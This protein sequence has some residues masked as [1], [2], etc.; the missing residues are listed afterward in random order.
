MTFQASIVARWLKSLPAKVASHY[1][2]TVR[3]WQLHLW[4]RPLLKCMRKAAWSNPSTCTPL[5]PLGDQV[6]FCILGSS[7]FSPRHCSR[8]RREPAGWRLILS[9]LYFSH[10][11]SLLP[12][13]SIT[14]T[15]Q[16]KLL[17]NNCDNKI[18]PS[19]KQGIPDLEAVILE[20]L[21]GYKILNI[22][23]IWDQ[24]CGVVSLAVTWKTSLPNR[25]WL[26]S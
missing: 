11:S 1:W 24:C 25:H 16:K 7:W 3:S 2:S 6:K 5:S 26:A 8:L 14:P 23:T 22:R 17:K 10:S 12:S 20:C 15:N 13:F 19:L 18:S 4:P 21:T 9:H